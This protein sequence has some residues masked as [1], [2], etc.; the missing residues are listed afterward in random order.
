[1]YQVASVG[2]G[3]AYNEDLERLPVDWERE[4]LSTVIRFCILKFS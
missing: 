1:M 2:L 4:K 3:L